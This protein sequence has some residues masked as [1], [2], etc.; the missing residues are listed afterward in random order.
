MKSESPRAEFLNGRISHLAAGFRLAKRR[1]LKCVTSGTM[2]I[3][4]SPPRLCTSRAKP[5][6]FGLGAAIF[7]FL[8]G[9]EPAA[10]S[11]KLRTSRT[12]EEVMVD[13]YRRRGG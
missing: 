9:R 6:K 4:L 10:P 5:F 13:V 12:S 11:P 8:L 2:A 7:C 1:F 3:G